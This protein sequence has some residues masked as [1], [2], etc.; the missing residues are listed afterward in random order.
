MR[1]GHLI[2]SSKIGAQLSLAVGMPHASCAGGPQ[3][4]GLPSVKSQDVV[5]LVGM[6]GGS[7]RGECG[8]LLV[9]DVVVVPLLEERRERV[10]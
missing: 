9:V 6:L 7:G 8:R 5:L 10:E 2:E 4:C 1:K 3:I